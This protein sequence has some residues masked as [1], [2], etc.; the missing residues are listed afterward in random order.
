MRHVEGDLLEA[1]VPKAATS[2]VPIE[3]RLGSAGQVRGGRW[4]CT[5]GGSGLREGKPKGAQSV[6]LVAGV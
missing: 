2:P 1:W 6:R 5:I 3:M 4:C